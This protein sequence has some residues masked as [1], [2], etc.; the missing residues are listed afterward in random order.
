MLDKMCIDLATGIDRRAFG[1]PETLGPVVELEWLRS[2][3]VKLPSLLELPRNRRTRALLR[4]FE[5]E[6]VVAAS[7]PRQTA[8][9]VRTLW[10]HE[11][12]DKRFYNFCSLAQEAAESAGIARACAQQLV[13]AIGELEDNIHLHSGRP[14]SGLL[15]FCAKDKTFEFIVADKGIGVLKSLQTTNP[16]ISDSG[17]ALDAA[18]RQGVSRFASGTGHGNG[19]RPLF[20]G[21]YNLNSLLRFRSG[22]FALVMDGRMGKEKAELFKVVDC[23]GFVISVF[24]RP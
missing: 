7:A 11:E 5:A 1:T 4:T 20:S 10:T 14:S 17:A 24:C 8:A 6:T 21:L 19:F 23:P 3:G 18:V 13:G 2:Q 22:D 15:A 16:A 12:D 9:F